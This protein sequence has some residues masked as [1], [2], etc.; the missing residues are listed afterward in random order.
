[1]AQCFGHV[2]GHLR[3]RLGLVRNLHDGDGHCTVAVKRQLAGEHLVQHDADRVD[4]GT[5]IGL[6]ALGLLGADVMH[7]ADGFV[8]DGLALRAGEARNAKVHHLNGAVRQQHDV[9]RLYIA[10]DDA[11]GVCVL[12][13]AE[14]LCGKVYSLFPGQGTAAL[15]EVFLQ[16]N[17][18]HILHHN[19]L[20]AIRHRD[21]VHLYDVRMAQ[22]RDGLGLVFKAA[23]QLFIIQKFFLQNLD[24]NGVAGLGVGAAVDVGHAAHADQTFDLISSVQTFSNEIIHD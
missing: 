17:A 5:G 24:G 16:R 19:V 1:M 13:G 20:Q 3:Q 11:L 7:R 10:V 14:H 18:V 2:G 21:I 23:D 6:I 12:Q 8:A 4:V 22:D 9:L 15:L